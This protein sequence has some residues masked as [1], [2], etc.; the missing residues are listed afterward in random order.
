MQA[1]SHAQLTRGAGLCHAHDF[2]VLTMHRTAELMSGGRFQ[3]RSIKTC[4]SGYLDTNA[5]I[6]LYVFDAISYAPRHC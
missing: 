4:T 1:P 6:K 2:W 5:L 3:G